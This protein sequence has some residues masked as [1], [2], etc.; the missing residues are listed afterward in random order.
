LREAERTLARIE[1][2]RGEAAGT[3][4]TAQSDEAKD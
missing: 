4:E 2:L 1:E 3:T